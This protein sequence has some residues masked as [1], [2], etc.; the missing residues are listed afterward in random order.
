MRGLLIVSA[1]A[2]GLAGRPQF[3]PDRAWPH[4]ARAGVDIA[5][6]AHRY[7][8]FAGHV[9]AIARRVDHFMTELE[10]DPAMMQA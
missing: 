8:G 6:L 10:P 3:D 9:A 7:A 2:Q 1:P 5:L 4:G